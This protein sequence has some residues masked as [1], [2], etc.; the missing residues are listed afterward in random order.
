MQGRLIGQ[1][2][3]D[4]T[5]DI[6]RVNTVVERLMLDSG[7]QAVARARSF[8]R[9]ACGDHT[10]DDLL[11]IRPG[12]IVRY[13]GQQPPIPE[14]RQDVTGTALQ[15]LAFKLQQRESRTGITRLNK[16]VDE[17]T[18]NDTAKG[19]A[20]LMA[21]GQQ[22]ERYI[23][24]NF[25]EGVARLFMKKVGLMR[26]Y[27]Q[28]FQIRVDGEYKQVDPSQWPEDM[29][30]QVTVGLAQAPSKSASCTASRSHRSTRC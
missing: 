4:K 28:P 23:I 15:I 21:R 9:T 19:Q 11:T 26:K 14:Q 18:L 17:D 27:A 30:V 2:L 12:R 16:G 24:R 1:S 6:Q 10:I 5:M 3:A 20:Q 13:A 7:Y 22:M 8:T 25:A 29:E